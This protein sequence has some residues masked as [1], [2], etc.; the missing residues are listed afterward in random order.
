MWSGRSLDD[1]PHDPGEVRKSFDNKL[2]RRKQLSKGNFIYVDGSMYF[3]E[4]SMRITLI[5]A[6]SH[7]GWRRRG[8]YALPSSAAA[9]FLLYSLHSHNALALLS[10]HRCPIYCEAGEPEERTVVISTYKK[11]A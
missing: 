10:L 8:L 4:S 11:I 2:I 1:Q 9:A 6:V 5:E 3:K 7:E